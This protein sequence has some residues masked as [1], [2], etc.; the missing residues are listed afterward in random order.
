M[1]FIP[2]KTSEADANKILNEFGAEG[3]EAYAVNQNGLDVTT[4]QYF[5]KRQK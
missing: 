1:V 5:F 4:G 2:E 3:W